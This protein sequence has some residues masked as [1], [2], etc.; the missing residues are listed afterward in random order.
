M[1]SLSPI[2]FE[3]L[4]KFCEQSLNWLLFYFSKI[5]KNVHMYIFILA[6]LQLWPRCSNNCYIGKVM[7]MFFLRFRSR[8]PVSSTPTCLWRSISRTST[9]LLSQVCQY[10]LDKSA[11]FSLFTYHR[12]V[13][14]EQ[15]KFQV[16]VFITLLFLL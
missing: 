9:R 11:D 6:F 1:C 10:Q 5:R 2:Y 8:R 12:R 14:F 3:V 13:P 15:L 7:F 16:F 4:R